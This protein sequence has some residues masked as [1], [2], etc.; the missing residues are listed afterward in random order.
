MSYGNLGNE[1]PSVSVSKIKKE[2]SLE[3][4]Q[5]KMKS[6]IEKLN[7]AYSTG[8]QPMIHQLNMIKATYT[9]AQVEMLEEMFGDDKNQDIEG[10]IDIS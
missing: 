9:R 7:Y 1:H 4:V 6:I 5:V 8:N 2:L 10:K 3:E